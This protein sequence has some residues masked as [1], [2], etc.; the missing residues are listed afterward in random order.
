MPED[1]YEGRKF[2]TAF[3]SHEL[4]EDTRT[5]EIMELGAQ[6]YSMGLLPDEQ[7]GHAGNM[8]FRNSKGFIITAGGAHKGKLTPMNFVQVLSVNTDTKTVEAEGGMEPSSETMMHHLIYRDRADANAIVHVHDKLVS[9]CAEQLGLTVTK[10]EHPYG[11]PEL[12][13]EVAKSLGHR[14]YVVIK[15]HGVLSFGKS[16]WEAGRII[17]TMHYAAEKLKHLEKEKEKQ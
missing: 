16:L 10:N 1:K 17:L 13:H 4:P 2:R 6:L 15:G 12:A 8:S 9:G 7:G 14:Q 5:A 3:L 11:T